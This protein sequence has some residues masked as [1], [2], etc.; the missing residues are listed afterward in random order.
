MKKK[1]TRTGKERMLEIFFDV[2]EIGKME[3]ISKIDFQSSNCP[4]HKLLSSH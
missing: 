4:S 3:R 2:M 1:I